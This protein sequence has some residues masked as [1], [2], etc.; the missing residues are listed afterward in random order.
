MSEELIERELEF[1]ETNVKGYWIS[2]VR[3]ST[4]DGQY[5][6]TADDEMLIASRG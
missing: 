5:L 3:L 6:Y 2:L 4:S 1:F